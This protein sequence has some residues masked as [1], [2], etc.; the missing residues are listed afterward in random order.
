MAKRTKAA[1]VTDAVEVKPKPV[2]QR[3]IVIERTPTADGFYAASAA[4]ETLQKAKDSA[5]HWCHEPA[6]CDIYR[7]PASDE[8]QRAE[9]D[10]D[11]VTAANF[12]NARR[13][14]PCSRTASIKLGSGFMAGSYWAGMG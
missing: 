1:K 6:D 8:A 3:Y 7:L 4:A 13:D 10:A 12:K 11:A 5:R 14:T 9:P 2:P